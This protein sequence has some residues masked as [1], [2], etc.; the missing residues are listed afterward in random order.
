[1]EE[2]IPA[3]MEKAPEAGVLIFIVVYFLK[4]MEK[5]R[6]ENQEYIQERDRVFQENLKDQSDQCHRLQERGREALEDATRVMAETREIMREVLLRG[7][8]RDEE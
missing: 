4:H 3:I 2:L 8:R 1:M 7:I 5:A 6:K